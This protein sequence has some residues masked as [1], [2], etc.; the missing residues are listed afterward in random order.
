ME[1]G[2]ESGIENGN[3]AEIFLCGKC[4]NEMKDNH[5][6]FHTNS[7]LNFKHGMCRKIYTDVGL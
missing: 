6:Y 1:N 3:G 2:M 5:S 7:I 4:Q